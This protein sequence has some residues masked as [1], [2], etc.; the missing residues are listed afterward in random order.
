[1]RKHLHTVRKHLSSALAKTDMR[2]A[3]FTLGLILIAFG[4]HQMYAPLAYI[5]PGAILV[6]ATA[7]RTV[8]ISAR[9]N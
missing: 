7:V 8:A 6:H 5:V 2:D 3:V 4:F 1:M 9:S